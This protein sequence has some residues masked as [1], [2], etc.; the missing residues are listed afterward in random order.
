LQIHKSQDWLLLNLLVRLRR[1]LGA[2]GDAVEGQLCGQLC[3]HGHL[4]EFRPRELRKLE[5]KKLT[6]L[7]P[8]RTL[9]HFGY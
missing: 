6:T 9:E 3:I 4:V 7:H 8:V 2:A 1:D 5:L